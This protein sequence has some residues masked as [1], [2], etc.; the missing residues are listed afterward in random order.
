MFPI[1]YDFGEIN[2][3][4]FS[5]HPVINSYGFMLMLAFYSCY[6]LLNKDL[7][8]QGHKPSLAGDI[9]FA[10]A[11]GGIVGSR[12]Y[13]ILENFEEFIADP[14]GMI[15][16]GGGLVFLGGLIGGLLAVTYVIN[17]NQLSWFMVADHVAPL[18]ILGYAIGRIGCLLVGDDYGLPT[19]LAWGIEFPNGIPPST[20]RVFQTQ[21]PWVDISNFTPGVLKVHPTQIYETLLGFGIFYYL[22]SKRKFV[23]VPGSL[24]FSYLILAGLE[25]FFIEFLR[26]NQKYFIGLSGAQLISLA[27][28]SVGLWFIFNPIAQLDE[29]VADKN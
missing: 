8:N 28:F 3:F 26:I 4:G 15:F 1:I 9:I 10:A 6:Y 21:Y 5:F 16:S 17:K 23:R 29:H 24:F 7:K 14:V 22:F 12:V 27:M 2:I 18:L 19:H 13:F 20:Y 11:V 25:R